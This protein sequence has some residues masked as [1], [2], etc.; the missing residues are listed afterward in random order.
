MSRWLT[1]SSWLTTA[2]PR[3]R[4]FN[5]SDDSYEAAENRESPKD[6][7]VQ[8]HAFEATEATE[9]PDVEGHRLSQATEA[10]EATE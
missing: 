6:D 1:T 3:E 10:T 5:V 9:E 7:D 8:G 4:S 2:H